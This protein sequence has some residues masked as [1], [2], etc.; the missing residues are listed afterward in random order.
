MDMGFP[1]QEYWNGLPFLS[2]GDLPSPGTEPV[3]P[4]LAGAFFTTSAPWD[5][6]YETTT[7][8][9]ISSEHGKIH[10][11]SNDYKRKISCSYLIG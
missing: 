6:K 8:N 3:S 2:P 11:F 1:R 7:L 4:A 9:F 10:D 5:D